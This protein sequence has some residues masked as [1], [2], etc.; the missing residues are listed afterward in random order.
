MSYL[1]YVGVKGHRHVQE[2]L[3]LFNPPNKIL[4]P[5]FELMG[6]LI[7]LFWVALPSL[8]QLFCCF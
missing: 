3:S 1:F 2:D 6:S 4:Y 5:V 7:N 8:S